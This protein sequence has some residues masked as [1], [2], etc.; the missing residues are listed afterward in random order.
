MRMAE[1]AAMDM[2]AAFLGAAVKRWKD[3]PGIEPAVR[4]KRAFDTRLQGEIGSVEHDRHE[5]SLFSADAVL[6][7]QNAA[8][9]DAKP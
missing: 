7:S 9:L 1:R 6:A 8:D 4:I 2:D 5:I 3:L